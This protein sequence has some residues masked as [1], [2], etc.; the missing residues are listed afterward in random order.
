MMLTNNDLRAYSLLVRIS[1]EPRFERK[2]LYSGTREI[3]LHVW[4]IPGKEV[5]AGEAKGSLP[6]PQKFFFVFWQVP[7]PQNLKFLS[8]H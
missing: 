2:E 4:D 8:L 7:L 5:V 1:T 6:L 3:D